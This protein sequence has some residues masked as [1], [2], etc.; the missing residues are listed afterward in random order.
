MQRIEIHPTLARTTRMLAFAA[1]ALTGGCTAAVAHADLTPGHAVA[2]GLPS[3]EQQPAF[4]LGTLVQVAVGYDFAVGIRPDWSV[5]AWGSSFDEI[6]AVPDGLDSCVKVSARMGHAVALAATGEVYAW[7]L[8]NHGECNVPANLDVAIDVAAGDNY[9]LAIDSDGKVYGWGYNGYGQASPP[10]NLAPCFKVAAGK[11]HSAAL[12]VNGK[13][14]CWG[15]NSYGQC[16][17][18]SGLP[19]CSKVACG[20]R[21]TVAL[22]NDGTVVCWGSNTYGQCSPPSGLGPCID[23]AAGGF[24]TVAVKADGSIVAWGYDAYGLLAPPLTGG[25][26]FAVAAGVTSWA[27]AL[28]DLGAPT[29]DRC[30]QDQRSD[31]VFHNKTSKAVNVWFMNGLAVSGGGPV[32]LTAASTKWKAEG[33]GDFDGDGHADILWRTDT[34]ALV[35]WFLVGQLVMEATEIEGAGALPKTWSIL[36]I[37]DINGDRMAD[38]VLRNP[39]TNTVHAWM[40]RAQHRI[41]TKTLGSANGFTFAA[42]GDFNGDGNVDLAFRTTENGAVFLWL[43]D[44]T[45]FS[46]GFVTNANPIASNWQVQATGDLDGDG[47]DDIVWRNTQ[48]GQVNGWLMDGL[49]RKAGGSIGAIALDWTLET[50]AD[51][52]GNGKGD[53]VWRNG[54]TTQVN[55]WMMDGLTKLS[56]GA[57]GTTG[58]GWTVVNR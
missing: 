51:L 36:A 25:P 58:S 12:L 27:L 17:V 45:A 35:I 7:G 31:I 43:L 37:G 30:N 24:Y 54:T 42:S 46:G 14:K 41:D 20:D 8:S 18:P 2:W 28:A 4:D 11:S 44:G 55:G 49:V 53:L 26:Y 52:D 19:S 23:V 1:A 38:L 29:R 9:S 10:S 16:S 57:I 21:H 22:R 50:S 15:S 40:M 56:G 13:V 48:D 39:L 32:S 3:N 5:V 6:L 33:L 34:G 47:N